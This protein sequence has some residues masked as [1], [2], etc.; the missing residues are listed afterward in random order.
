MLLTLT[1]AGV[2][3][4]AGG[5]E[6]KLDEGVWTQTDVSGHS[7]A[8]VGLL[9]EGERRAVGAA[10]GHPSPSGVQEPRAPVGGGEVVLQGA[11]ATGAAT[12]HHLRRR[13]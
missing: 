5:G 3:D 11:P 12:D 1:V 10:H 2:G 6:V 9:Y 4:G 13:T 7:V 8:S